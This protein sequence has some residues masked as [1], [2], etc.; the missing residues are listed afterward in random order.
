[1][2]E[3]PIS[4]IPLLP[5][6]RQQALRIVSKA[7]KFRSQCLIKSKDGVINAKSVLGLMSLRP[8]EHR[9]SCNGA[10]EEQAHETLLELLS[11]MISEK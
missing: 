10:D 8:G 2:R 5:F 7:D 3:T 6:N 1:M 9:L 11:D 4:I